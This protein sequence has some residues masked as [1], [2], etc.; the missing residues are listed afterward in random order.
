MTTNPCY[1]VLDKFSSSYTFHLPYHTIQEVKAIPEEVEEHLKPHFKPHSKTSILEIKYYLVLFN[2]KSH[3]MFGPPLTFL[4]P[5]KPLR[6]GASNLKKRIEETVNDDYLRRE[7]HE[8][9]IYDLS[10]DTPQNIIAVGVRTS[11]PTLVVH[12]ER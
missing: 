5:K 12:R 3:R 2:S 6:Q 9:N 10:G 11:A 4:Q 8:I 7:C 1:L